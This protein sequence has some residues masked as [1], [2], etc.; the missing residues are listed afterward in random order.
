MATKILVNGKEVT[1]PF[2]KAFLVL[3]AIITVAIVA[4]VV[5]FILLP[6]IGVAVTLSAWV[7]AIFIAAIV[8]GI[9]S[10]AFVTALLA[11]LFGAMEFHFE[12]SRRSR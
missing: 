2:V 12:K 3:G 9:T 7:I 6:I 1:N 11:M 4:A 5:I 8:V 10:L